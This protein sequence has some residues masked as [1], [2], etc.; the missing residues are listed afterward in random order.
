MYAC[1]VSVIIVILA[2]ASISMYACTVSVIIVIL[3]IASISMMH[4]QYQ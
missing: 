3:A 4:V 2:I 1:T